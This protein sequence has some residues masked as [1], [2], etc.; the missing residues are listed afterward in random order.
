MPLGVGWSGLDFFSSSSLSWASRG[1]MW[2]SLIYM[3][4]HLLGAI[5]SYFSLFI[6]RK[7]RSIQENHQTSRHIKTQIS[8]WVGPKMV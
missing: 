4:G 3:V 5:S 2:K 8:K 1:N 7:L 6:E